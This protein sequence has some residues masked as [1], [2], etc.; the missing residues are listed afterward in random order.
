[1]ASRTW[2]PIFTS[3]IGNQQL[4][5]LQGYTAGDTITLSIQ[6]SNYSHYLAGVEGNIKLG[7]FKDL[8]NDMFREEALNLFVAGSFIVITITLIVFYIMFSFHMQRMRG[9]LISY[10]LFCLVIGYRIVGSGSYPLHRL[11]HNMDYELSHSSGIHEFS[12]SLQW[13]ESY[14]CGIYTPNSRIN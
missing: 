6:I 2:I 12:S 9:E 7:S 14:T 10:A 5:P 8:E 11:I 3:L 1:M 13:P 4:F